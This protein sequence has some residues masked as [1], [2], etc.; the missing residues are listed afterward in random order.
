[1]RVLIIFLMAMVAFSSESRA[2]QIYNYSGTITDVRDFNGTGIEGYI[3]FGTVFSGSFTYDPT[4]TFFFDNGDRGV[5]EA[6]LDPVLTTVGDYQFQS[7]SNQL[8][9]GNGTPGIYFLSS[10][11][12]DFTGLPPSIAGSVIVTRI[13]LY[14]NIEN[15]VLPNKLSLS[16]F[17]G[18]IGIT[19]YSSSAAAP[20]FFSWH[21][22]GNITSLES[23]AAV[24]ETSTWMM[25]IL[26]LLWLDLRFVSATLPRQR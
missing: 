18:F 12:S 3:P 19:G 22:G 8:Q 9:I 17:P 15:Y 26:G 16:N 4:P 14:G 21:I 1:M 23:V 11:L 24:P 6:P 7:L 25:L 20:S 5:F 13:Q 2:A 10:R